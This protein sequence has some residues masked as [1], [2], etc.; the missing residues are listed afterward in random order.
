MLADQI[1]TRFV[2]ARANVEQ[3]TPSLLARAFSGR[4]VPQDP[5]DP[6]D[7]PAAALLDRIKTH[8]ETKSRRDARQ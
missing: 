1:E 6:K 8:H 3:L 5:K 2:Q 7:E 4:L